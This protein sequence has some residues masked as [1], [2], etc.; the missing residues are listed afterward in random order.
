MHRTLKTDLGSALRLKFALGFALKVGC[1]LLVASY[2]PGDAT[3]NA[4]WIGSGASA[5]NAAAFAEAVAMLGAPA[6][7]HRTLIGTPFCKEMLS[8][9]AM[10]GLRAVRLWWTLS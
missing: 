6:W 10:C 2:A 8:L 7:R 1:Q 9:V 3:S 5:V 4:A